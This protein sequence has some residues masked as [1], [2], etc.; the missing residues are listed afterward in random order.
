MKTEIVFLVITLMLLGCNNKN[1]NSSQPTNELSVD[2]IIGIGKVFPQG[3]IIELAAPA[4]GIVKDVYFKAGD[5]LNEGDLILMLENSDEELSV[6][7][8]DSRMASQKLAMES[9]RLTFEQEKLAH[10]EQLRLLDDAQELLKVGASTGE[11]VRTLQN[12]FDQGAKHLKKLENDYKMEQSQLSEMN[13]QRTSRK[14]DLDKKI[15]KV[16]VDGILLDLSIKTGEA[17]SLYQP[18]GRIA[19]SSPLVVKA[20]IDELFADRLKVGQSCKIN[21]PGDSLIVAIG[22]LVY[23]SPDLKKKSLF[24][25]SGTDL[26]DRR[27]REIEVSLKEIYK[28]L[29]IESKVECSVQLNK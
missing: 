24:S 27:I 12:E 23:I 9:A 3:G 4:S 11:K 2:S 7:E 16:P 19:P 6:K 14:N 29:F 17:V 22:E 5:S 10:A 13:I 26:E 1:K 18:Y 28:T 8:V 21:I 20:E 25:D 15:F